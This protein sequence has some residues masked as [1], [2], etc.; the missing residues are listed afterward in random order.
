L[1][2]SLKDI[3]YT[4]LVTE[5]FTK[6]LIMK[7]PEIRNNESQSNEDPKYLLYAKPKLRKHGKVN[8]I[9]KSNFGGFSFD[10]VFGPTDF[11]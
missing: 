5:L 6:E 7:K 1:Q 3:D 11:S 4:L 8:N 2:T 10:V 9:T